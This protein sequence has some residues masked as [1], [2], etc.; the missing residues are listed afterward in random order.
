[1]SISN[2][3][4]LNYFFYLPSYFFFNTVNI[5]IWF[6]TATVVIT[7]V[8]AVFRHLQVLMLL[9]KMMM[10]MMRINHI[11]NRIKAVLGMLLRLM[12]IKW[13]RRRQKC[14]QWDWM[15]CKGRGWIACRWERRWRWHSIE[16]IH[17]IAG[18]QWWFWHT[19]RKASIWIK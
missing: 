4:I 19:V 2:R 8:T 7:I 10:M 14:W 17:V 15:R 12:V 9:I 3:I 16:F 18:R 5:T 1:M 6:A 11:W 13:I